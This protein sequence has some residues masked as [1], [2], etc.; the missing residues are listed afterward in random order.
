MAEKHE[1]ITLVHQN[2]VS[3]T[4]DVGLK[5]LFPVLWER[6]FEIYHSCQEY[7]PGR[8]MMEFLDTNSVED[9]IFV[10]EKD[11]D[12]EIVK[13]NEEGLIGVHL[14]VLFPI[15]DI[16]DL[17]IKF[18]TYQYESGLCDHCQNTNDK[19]TIH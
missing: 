16:P 2:G 9:F 17:V 19:K 7:V 11:Y 5:D 15:K 3:H 14:I 10:A 12:V 13:S 18:Q 1:K 4:I 6:G 8:A